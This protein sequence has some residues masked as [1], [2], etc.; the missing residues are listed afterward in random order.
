MG[1]ERYEMNELPDSMMDYTIF[2]GN[3]NEFVQDDDLSQLFQSVSSLQTVPACV[4]RK[5]DMSSLEYGFVSFPSVE[6][7]EVRGHDLCTALLPDQLKL[8][9]KLDSWI[10]VITSRHGSRSFSLFL[11]FILERLLLYDFMEQ[12]SKG[13]H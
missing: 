5:P 7:K 8:V 11:D 6:E 3:L 12:Y 2:V 1:G 9:A 4:V 10:F 13:E